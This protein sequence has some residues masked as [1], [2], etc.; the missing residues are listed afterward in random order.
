MSADG[1]DLLDPLKREFR[2]LEE[3]ECV[4]ASLVPSGCLGEKFPFRRISLNDAG[5]TIDT[6]NRL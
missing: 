2:F 5:L 4:M 6:Y 1:R 3:S